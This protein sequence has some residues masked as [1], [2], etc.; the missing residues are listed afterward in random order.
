M[1]KINILILSIL[2]VG[3]G[4]VSSYA[5]SWGTAGKILTAIEGVRIITGDRVDV[6]GSIIGGVRG[7]H[8]DTG[9]RKSRRNHHKH[10]NTC[11]HR[12]RNHNKKYR[13]CTKEVW[14]PHYEWKKKHVPE[15]EEYDAQLG[16][17]YVEEHYIRY[18]VESGG[19]WET[20]S[21]G[22]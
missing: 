13:N 11:S 19:H 21:C 10:S 4:A 16:S 6:V 15:Y 14:V 12:N 2:F 5:S 1:K 22:H 8:S 9:Y 17:V 3:V 7:R 20:I 18:K